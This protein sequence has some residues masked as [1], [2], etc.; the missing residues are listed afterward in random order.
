MLKHKF[1]LFKL[2]MFS[3]LNE[4]EKVLRFNQEEVRR[5][6]FY[7]KGSYFKHLRLYDFV[8]NNKQLS[9]VKRITVQLNAPKLAGT[10]NEAL[11]LGAED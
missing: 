7:V 8:F 3:L 5:T 10:L 2:M 4:G 11:L 9:E 1:E 6:I